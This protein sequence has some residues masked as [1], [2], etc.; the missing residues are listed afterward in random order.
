MNG[1]LAQRRAQAMILTRGRWATAALDIPAPVD[2]LAATPA[3][4]TTRRGRFAVAAF[5]LSR[6]LLSADTYDAQTEILKR[7][8][9]ILVGAVDN[10]FTPIVGMRIEAWEG[11]TWTVDGLN[12]TAPDGCTAVVYTGT[13]RR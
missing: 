5:P 12:P 11:S 1:T 9:A 7:S 4:P 8:R 6:R 2:V 10:P 3:Q 13:M